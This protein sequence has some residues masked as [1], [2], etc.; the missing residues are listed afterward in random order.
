M[1]KEKLLIMS[2]FSFSHSFF[3]LFEELSAIF[4]EIW[5][6]R[7]QTLRVWKGLKFVIWKTVNEKLFSMAKYIPTVLIVS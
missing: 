5:K 6:Y 4:I 3:Y 2:N 1:E 7:Q